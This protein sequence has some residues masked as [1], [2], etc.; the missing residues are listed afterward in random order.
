M[1]VV[2]CPSV[3]RVGSGVGLCPA[4]C[5]YFESKAVERHLAKVDSSFL[6]FL[7]LQNQFLIMNESEDVKLIRDLFRKAD[8]D[9]DGIISREELSSVMT[10][11]MHG[12]SKLF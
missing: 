3:M 9:K 4:C 6:L 8:S 5:R 11:L 1:I 7:A 10:A 12:K 2:C